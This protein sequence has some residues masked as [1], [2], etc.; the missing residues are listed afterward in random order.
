M[1]SPY[2][3]LD[4]ATLA[5]EQPLVFFETVRSG[6]ERASANS[7]E[8]VEH[9]YSIGGY[10]VRLQ[11]AGRALVECLTPAFE[12]LRI[13]PRSGFDLSV[14]LWDST[15]THTHL[16]PP[17]WAPEDCLPRC[18][19][20]DYID[21]RIQ[22]SYEMVKKILTVLDTDSNQGYFWIRDA[23]QLPA[24]QCGS[25]LLVLL[26]QWMTLHGRSLVHG[27]AV[28]TP[29]GGVLLVGKGGSGKSTATLC[30]LDSP[31]LY[32][33]DDYGLV[34]S[35]PEPYFYSL[36]SSGKVNAPDVSKHPIIAEARRAAILDTQKALY[37][38]YSH[39]PEKISTGFPLR[40]I[41]VP[42]VTHQ[43]ETR[44]RPASAAQALLALA[45]STLFQL[46]GAES[47]KFGRL[48]HLVKTLPAY[49]LESGTDWSQIPRALGELVADLNA[50]AARPL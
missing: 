36:Y 4:E 37:F 31:L 45:P 44:V 35:E 38:L 16:P 9:F 43:L 32:A 41:V 14:G 22:V 1:T 25:P 48:S 20:R 28:G 18:S 27:G 3:P 12:H 17:P 6:F 49:A 46:P 39:F 34:G 10:C 8:V 5:S 7:G 13:E 23:V 26:H 19:V 2:N 15:S 11:F 42:R 50:R 24:Y 29:E 33:A 40:A 47:Q 21:T 30:C